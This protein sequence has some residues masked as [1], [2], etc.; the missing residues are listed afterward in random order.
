MV[1]RYQSQ[2]GIGRSE[3]AV[4]L[5]NQ[6]RY[7]SSEAGFDV[8]KTDN[9]HKLLL[10]A[11]DSKSFPLPIGAPAASA[12]RTEPA[13]KSLSNSHSWPLVSTR[14]SIASNAHV[15]CL[16]GRNPHHATKVDITTS[17]QHNIAAKDAQPEKD[18]S[19][20]WQDSLRSGSPIPRPPKSGHFGANTTSHY[21]H[22][23]YP[24]YLAKQPPYSHPNV[25]YTS[26][27][28]QF[29]SPSPLFFK[30]KQ[31]KRR[32]DGMPVD[33]MN[34]CYK[35]PDHHVIHDRG[36]VSSP[37]YDD[38]D[39][40]SQPYIMADP[41]DDG[42]GYGSRG[43]NHYCHTILDASGFAVSEDEAYPFNDESRYD[44]LSNGYVTKNLDQNHQCLDGET[45][46]SFLDQR[47]DHLRNKVPLKDNPG[48]RSLTHRMTGNTFL[49]PDSCKPETS[50]MK[51]D[52]CEGSNRC[53]QS[54]VYCGG[55]QGE[56]DT[57]GVRPGSS[58]L[59]KSPLTVQTFKG[60]VMNM[61]KSKSPSPKRGLGSVNRINV[62]DTSSSP[63]TK[64]RQTDL[65]YTNG[66]PF[67][68]S[69][70]GSQ[71]QTDCCVKCS[72]PTSSMTPCEVVQ[73]L[74]LIDKHKSH[75]H[76]CHQHKCHEH[77]S[78]EHK[79]H[80][81][82]SHA[83]SNNIGSPKKNLDGASTYLPARMPCVSPCRVAVPATTRTSAP[84]VSFVN[85][86]P[87]N[88]G[89][90]GLSP[91]SLRSDAS[92]SSLLGGD[93]PKSPQGVGSPYLNRGGDS[94]KSP[95]GAPSA[96]SPRGGESPMSPLSGEY[97]HSPLQT[98]TLRGL[99][100]TLVF[101]HNK[102]KLAVKSD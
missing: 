11:I 68:Q 55:R 3:A 30:L 84:S 79:C 71:F 35:V 83:T 17:R 59:H 34:D 47:A 88:T 22:R 94:P 86:T 92:H 52:S 5:V 65:V 101:Q 43:H 82:K 25:F 54:S 1:A 76:K 14:R 8:N 31:K 96:N 29:T 56:Y 2:L 4:E 27:N 100:P 78:H 85:R 67:H 50:R 23:H 93:S 81:H 24:T 16:H 49:S 97:L 63:E 15:N 61:I 45:Y 90:V 40:F 9:P 60:S 21:Q 80:E 28:S 72:N 10:G 69:L 77:K 46:Q 89:R 64:L 13:L 99:D 26:L 42:F 20:V 87:D 102:R 58:V 37:F 62:I 95:R 53:Q 66:A 39:D 74:V 33:D 41:N 38:N 98:P 75:E 70:P 6:N 44:G 7:Y 19:P 91:K 36:E 12:A 32:Y 73:D 51:L 48:K 18:Q 57:A